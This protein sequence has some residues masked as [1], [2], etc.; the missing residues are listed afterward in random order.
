[1]C[2]D[3]PRPLDEDT[4][5]VTRLGDGPAVTIMDRSFAA[6]PGILG[7]LRASAQAENIAIQYKAPGLGGTDAGA[8]HTSRAGVPSGTVAVPC[9]YIHSPAAILNLNDLA[10]TVCLVGAALRRIDRSHVTREQ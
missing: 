3:S 2:D 7:L 10:N 1:V 9:R 4:T 5:P 8:I 6:H